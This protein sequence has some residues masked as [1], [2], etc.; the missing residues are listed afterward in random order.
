ME[1][2]IKNPKNNTLG[3]QIKTLEKILELNATTWKAL[4]LAEEKI[5]YPWYLAGGAVY[6]SVWNYYSNKK[7][8]ENIN[9]YD[10]FYFNKKHSDQKHKALE[11]TF[12]K[13]LRN[14]Q[15]DLTN[16]ATIHHWLKETLNKDV[17]AYSSIEEDINSFGNS[18]A[19]VAV[20]LNRGKIEVYAPF[21]LRDMFALEV[22]FSGGCFTMEEHLIKAN[23]W[24]DRWPGL[25]IHMN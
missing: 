22:R 2:M 14:V 16:I 7:I 17:S 13:E 21:G 6:H 24:K 8:D 9:D 1:S 12:N 5:E 3:V 11:Q 19:S 10:I 18:V 4:K 20:R 23:S 15:V 25:T